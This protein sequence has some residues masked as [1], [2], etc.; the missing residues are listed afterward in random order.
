MHEFSMRVIQKDQVLV[1][2][3]E[4]Y[5]GIHLSMYLTPRIKIK[6]GVAEENAKLERIGISRGLYLELLCFFLGY[7]LHS[8]W[9]RILLRSEIEPAVTCVR[10]PCAFQ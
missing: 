1:I 2:L 8:D 7:S 6:P 9:A 3:Y 10:G 4:L 5:T